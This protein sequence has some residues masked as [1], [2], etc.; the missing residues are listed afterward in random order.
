MP[1]A[2]GSKLPCRAAGKAARTTLDIPALLA[3]P[4]AARRR[5]AGKVLGRE[6]LR[7]YTDADGTVHTL[8]VIR[9]ALALDIRYKSIQALQTAACSTRLQERVAAAAALSTA[10]SR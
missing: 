2:S 6:A 3:K 8:I 7:C 4:L 1:D 5:L 9:R 10:A